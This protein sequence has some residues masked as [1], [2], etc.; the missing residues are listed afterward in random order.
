MNC[1]I[2]FD[3]DITTKGVVGGGHLVFSLGTICGFDHGK[4]GDTRM[5]YVFK[6][7]SGRPT[8]DPV[9]VEAEIVIEDECSRRLSKSS[10]FA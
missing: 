1:I 4:K 8:E 9:E 7:G 5:T 2:G 10:T 3:R 6:F